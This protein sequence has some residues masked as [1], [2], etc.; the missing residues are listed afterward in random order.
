[1][2]EEETHHG[3]WHRL[4][5][6]GKTN[7]TAK[8]YRE[9]LSTPEPPPTQP[10]ANDTAPAAQAPAP[11]PAQPQAAPAP[12][13]EIAD[14]K[15][16][17]KP[18]EPKPVV[19]GPR[20]SYSSPAKPAPGDRRA[21]EGPFTKARMAEQDENWTDAEQWYQTAADADPS[22]FEAQFNTGV[23]AHRLHSYSVALPRYE[24]ALAIQPASVDARYNF[25]LALKAAGYPLDAADELKRVLASSPD[26]V[27]A[28][29][30][31]ANLCAQTL[32]DV[33]QA[34]QHYLR[35]LELQP[36]NPQAA[37]IRFWLSANANPAK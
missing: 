27:R 35:V 3:F 37:D 14:T 24:L 23:I 32:H 9:D 21:A 5:N 29:L 16:E 11:V 34:R 30:A 1:M 17:E 19:T 15:P 31:L 2:P 33:P 25:A 18:A 10:S 8:R 26:E 6:A 12:A 22:W 28:Q 7:S 36:D 4:F 20:Y 13:E